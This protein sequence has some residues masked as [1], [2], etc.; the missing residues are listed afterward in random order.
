MAKK[1]IE[2]EV[3]RAVLIWTKN[4]FKEQIE[5]QIEK[6]KEVFNFDIPSHFVSVGYG[7]GQGARKVYDEVKFEE[8]KIVKNQWV[9]VTKEI[10]R[11]AFDIPNNEYHSQFSNAGNVIAVMGNQDWPTEYKKEVSRKIAALESLLAQLPFIQ[12][13]HAEAKDEP[14]EKS[15]KIF[16]SHSSDDAEFA[17]SLVHLLFSIGFKPHE[18]FCSSVPGCWVQEGKNF[19]QVIKEQFDQH[20]LYLIFIHSPRLYN[21]HVSMNEM[22]AAW[23]L[24][25]EYSSFLTTD[26]QFGKMDAVVRNTDIAIK[27]DD[28]YAKHRMNEWKDRL[29]AWFGKD[30]IDEN[31]W[32]T[33][34]DDFIKRMNQIVYPAASQVS[35]DDSNKTVKLKESDIKKL[36]EWVASGDNHFFQ[37]WYEGG[38]ATF[39]LGAINQYEVQSGREM[40]E[41]QGFL[42]R[43][44]QGGFVNKK[45]NAKKHPDYELTEKAYEYFDK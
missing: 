7:Y 45:E 38:S 23:V 31:I 13:Q 25:S 42:S 12:C 27:I 37:V 40:A 24:Q 10:L 18:I 28:E 5:T 20:K 35:S 39:G 19:C 26:M 9:D 29:I 36:K 22:G 1:N 2:T 21:S 4:Q 15:K 33:F 8:F 34:R 43:L 16:I 41:W 30:K 17:V 6:G 44:T 11:Q 3:R 14:I 32:E